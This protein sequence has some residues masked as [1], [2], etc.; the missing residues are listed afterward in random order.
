MNSGWRTDKSGEVP[1]AS[2]QVQS[3]SQVGSLNVMFNFALVLF[4]VFL[5]FFFLSGS[6]IFYS[7][8]RLS[9][10]L[11][12]F[13]RSLWLILSLSVSL[14]RC[15]FSL[16]LC[17]QSMSL[18]LSFSVSFPR[19]SLPLSFSVSLSPCLYVFFFSVCLLY[20]LSR[21]L[22]YFCLCLIPVSVLF[23]SL[24]HSCLWLILVSV[25]YLFVSVLFLSLSY[26]YLWSLCLIH[27]V[28]GREWKIPGGSR[29]W[30]W[31]P[32]TLLASPTRGCGTG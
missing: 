29:T 30:W 14:C 16:P 24:A 25:L 17:L 28:T 9:V 19:C 15:S 7:T 27:L 1:R 22:S 32:W 31:R 4:S 8:V 18:C 3:G 2:Y 21:S 13:S 5:K 11:S 23:L 12:F 20:C 6:L 10:C 26:F